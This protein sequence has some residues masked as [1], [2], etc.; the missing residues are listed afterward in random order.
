MESQQ[1]EVFLGHNWT[2]RSEYSEAI[3]CRIDAQV[4]MIGILS[5]Y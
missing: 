2:T 3:A 4:R 1:G 5:F